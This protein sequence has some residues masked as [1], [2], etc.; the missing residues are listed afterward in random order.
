MESEVDTPDVELKDASKIDV[1]L[2]TNPAELDTKSSNKTPDETKSIVEPSK[3]IESVID[4]DINEEEL[5]KIKN[6]VKE[7][8]A[9]LE[10]A[11]SE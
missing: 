6:S 2:Q 3:N 5:E 8:I 4:D 9:K 10:R 7:A 1:T 11:E